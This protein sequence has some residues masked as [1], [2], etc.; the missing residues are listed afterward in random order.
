MNL[1]NV[2]SYFFSAII[3]V[4]IQSFVKFNKLEN[5]THRLHSY[6]FRKES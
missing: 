2:L 5:S 4:E 3:N 6:R 1:K